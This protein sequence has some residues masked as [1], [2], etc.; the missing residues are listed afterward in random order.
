MTQLDDIGLEYWRYLSEITNTLTD[1]PHFRKKIEEYRDYN[2]TELVDKP[3]MQYFQTSDMCTVVSDC[4]LRCILHWSQ[5]QHEWVFYYSK[6]NEFF[7]MMPSLLG[8]E[9]I[10][11]ENVFINISVKCYQNPIC[12]GLGTRKPTTCTSESIRFG[13][14]Q[15]RHK[16]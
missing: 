11:A 13:K 14:E 8:L 7:L 10:E 5:I 6:G 15:F 16:L 4:R 3:C 2:G 9:Y 12:H 1:D